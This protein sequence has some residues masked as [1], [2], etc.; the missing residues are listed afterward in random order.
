MLKPVMSTPGSPSVIQWASRAE[1]L[2]LI[3]A[4]PDLAGKAAVR[5]ELTPESAREQRGAGLDACTPEQFARLQRLNSAYR[6]RFGFPFIL[7]VRGHTPDSVIA[8]ME[9]RIPSDGYD[10]PVAVAEPLDMLVEEGLVW[11]HRGN[12]PGSAMLGHYTLCRR[13]KTRC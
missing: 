8:A 10:P 11:L 5:N 12:L 7:A 3:R 1:Q 4:H 2:E 6:E 9:Q 13:G